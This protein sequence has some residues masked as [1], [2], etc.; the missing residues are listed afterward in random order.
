M[1]EP[2]LR[3]RETVPSASRCAFQR[4]VPLMT[5]AAALPL[6]AAGAPGGA[7]WSMLVDLRQCIGCQACTIACIQENGVP[8][9]SFRTLVSIYS[10]KLADQARQPAATYVLPRLCN[11]CDDPRCVPV[12]PVGATFKREDDVAL[13]DAERCVGLRL[14]CA[15]LPLRCPLHQPWDGQGRQ[16][17]LLRP[18][19]GGRLAARCVETCVGGARIFGNANDADSEIRRRLDAAGPRA[20]T[21]KPEEGTRPRV[22]YIGLEPH[23]RRKVDGEGVRWKPRAHGGWS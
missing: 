14:L 2:A 3:P 5:A 6:S 1:T 4:D 12:C 11:R 21:L 15:G 7:R 9:N 8:E 19:P 17:H 16:M 23:L 13:V 22:F 18:P 20:M 10:V